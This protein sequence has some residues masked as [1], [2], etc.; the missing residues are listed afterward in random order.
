MSLTVERDRSFLAHLNKEVLQVLTCISDEFLFSNNSGCCLLCGSIQFKLLLTCDEPSV[1]FS[2]H[3]DFLNCHK[4][5]IEAGR[6][7]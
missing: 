4:V 3:T 5:R 1:S 2:V 6:N 7:P